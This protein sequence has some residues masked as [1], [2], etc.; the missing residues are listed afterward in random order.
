MDHDPDDKRALFQQVVD[1]ILDQIRDGRLNP[2]DPLPSARKMADVYGVAS[3]TA[4]RALRELQHRRLILKA[5]SCRFARASRQR[6]SGKQVVT[7]TPTAT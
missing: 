7:A 5:A 3:M 6:G 2:N 4:Q 1:D